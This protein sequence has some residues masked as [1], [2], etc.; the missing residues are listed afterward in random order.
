VAE[1]RGKKKKFLIMQPNDVTMSLSISCSDRMGK[2]GKVGGGGGPNILS[3]PELPMLRKNKKDCEK[4][5]STTW[6]WREPFLVNNVEEREKR[7]DT[8]SVRSIAVRDGRG[9]KWRIKK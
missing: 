5:E 3:K 6:D 2:G 1:R 7:R 4:K 9:K 8:I